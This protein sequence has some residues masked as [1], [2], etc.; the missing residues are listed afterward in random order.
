MEAHT[1][2]EVKQYQPTKLRGQRRNTRRIRDAFKWV[3]RYHYIE[4]YETQQREPV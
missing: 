3:Q 2:I 1:C 4:T